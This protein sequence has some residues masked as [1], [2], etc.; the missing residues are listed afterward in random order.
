MPFSD[1]E[2]P[3]FAAKL[4]AQRYFVKTRG[5]SKYRYFF[6]PKCE[7]FRI[8]IHC[9][10]HST[11]SPDCIFI[12]FFCCLPILGFAQHSLLKYPEAARVNQVDNYHGYQIQDP[13]RWMENTTSEKTQQWM[14]EQDEL[15]RTYLE[16]VP[17]RDRIIK[18]IERLADTGP[19]YSVPTEAAGDYFFQKFDPSLNHAIIYRQKGLDSPPSKVLDLNAY[20]GEKEQNYGGYSVCPDGK[21][22][23]FL[24]TE[25][26]SR[27]GDLQ[28]FSIE[29]KKVQNDKIG[30]IAGIS[31]IWK[32][33]GKGFYYITYGDTKK[34]Q[35]KEESPVPVLKYHQL[36]TPSERDQPI[37]SRPDLPNAIFTT[38][39]TQDKRQLVLSL[40]DG[41]SDRNEV[42]LIDMESGKP[43]GLIEGAEDLY[44]F[45]GKIN[46]DYYFY[47][48]QNAVNGKVIKIDSET[49]KRA[50]VVPEQESTLAGGSSQGGNAMN[51]IGDQLVL[52][53]RDGTQP[54][55]RTYNLEGKLQ[56]ELKLETGWIG[57]G[58]VGHTDGEAAWYSLNTFLEPSTVYRLDLK[59]GEA[60][61]FFK[62]TL[63][64]QLDDYVTKN[65]QYTSKDGTRVPLFIAHK[66][67][68]KLNGSNPVFMYGY[69]F[70]GWVAVPWYQPHMLTWL[71][72]GGIFVLPGIRGGGEY[73]DAWREA[74]LRDKRQNAI[75]D[76]LA[77][78]KYMIDQG[79]TSM[80][81]V[82][83]NGW[84]AS[85][86][87]A[88]AAVQQRPDL[89]GAA[90]IG[91]PSLDLLR[92]QHFT[93]FKGWTRSYG[94]SEN[95]EEFETLLSWSP[96]HNIG[97]MQCYPPM[98]VTIG[99]KD[100]VTPPQH[101]CK[102]VAAMQEHQNCSQPVLLKVV[103]GGGHGF[104]TT[105][106]QT[107]ETYADELSF[108]VK[109]L[110]M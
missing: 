71:E 38:A 35:S 96:Y 69:G 76:Y 74:G 52:L 11:K 58:L 30:G 99:E 63:P 93:A 55:I 103:W 109:A 98:L 104:G 15:L 34:L 23:A 16:S 91:I 89:F 61:A 106:E 12:F 78:A 31:L 87:L 49:G 73:G 59:T 51:L 1:Y 102:F 77:A 29:D 53:Y 67:G 80:G 108:L 84:S 24:V 19:S 95:K 22:L 45:I 60:K 2:E 4:K 14:H 25:S 70:G 44:A 36:G 54:Y 72:M 57:S 79:Y 17:M 110:G 50:T 48:N 64:I 47:T 41:R 26:Q 3:C 43:R 42:Y 86:S 10:M 56:H 100:E 28:L 97:T 90:L 101:G 66:K 92:Y 46:S 68:L 83:A 27:W 33:D 5:H 32:D 75:D 18:N 65:I 107:R 13:Y 21:K 7:F 105:T 94:S 62:R 82:V 85:G 81:K 8:K 9:K 40:F 37:Y 39:V 6:H 20:I 88:A